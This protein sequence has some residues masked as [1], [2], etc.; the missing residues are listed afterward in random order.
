M[1][2]VY[3]RL[4]F[5]MVTLRPLPGGVWLLRVLDTLGTCS[6]TS[7]YNGYRVSPFE[8]VFLEEHSSGEISRR[9]DNWYVRGWD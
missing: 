4:N 3:D 7:T 9:S 8:R 6:A 5:D 1:L 2:T